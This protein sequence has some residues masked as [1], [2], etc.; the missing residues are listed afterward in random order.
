MSQRRK[1]KDVLYSTENE[2]ISARK[3]N[4]RKLDSRKQ[5]YLPEGNNSNF[6]YG[7]YYDNDDDKE[8]R[9]ILSTKNAEKLHKTFD[10][11]HKSDKYLTE[12][13]C[14]NSNSEQYFKRYFT[15][16]SR[17]KIKTKNS[18]KSKIYSSPTD[19][20]KKN[21][22]S[23]L[24]KCGNSFQRNEF[25]EDNEKEFLTEEQMENKLE[26]YLEGSARTRGFY[27]TK[28][29]K[30]EF[31]RNSSGNLKNEAKSGRKNNSRFEKQETSRDLNSR[32][33]KKTRKR[34][35]NLS[36]NLNKKYL[37]SVTKDSVHSCD[38]KKLKIK[39]AGN[40]QSEHVSKSQETTKCNKKCSFESNKSKC[41]K[42][43]SKP[44]FK[45]SKLKDEKQEIRPKNEIDQNRETKEK[46]TSKDSDS[47]KKNEKF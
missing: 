44:D 33:Q 32:R 29:R 6:R 20:T 30:Y 8:R 3:H 42:Y 11:K 36:R 18:P 47:E 40:S 23:G 35:E 21:R 41:D 38:S 39:K 12:D 2:E 46:I 1:V 24:E 34:N 43:S 25:N 15:D 45:K 22:K 19:E 16:D 14:H 7:N 28:M 4:S 5:K 9:R 27:L 26:K 10:R 17:R 37:E 13:Y 31:Q